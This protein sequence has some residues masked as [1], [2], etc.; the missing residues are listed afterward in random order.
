M[1]ASLIAVRAIHFAAQI[2]LAGIFAFGALVAA[3][4]YARVSHPVPLGL[5]R[6]LM[7]GAGASVVLALLSAIPWLL[8]VTQS[9][10]AKPLSV[11]IAQG[12]ILTVLTGTQF[13]HAWALRFGV[14][15]LLIPFVVVLGKSRARDGFAA[16]LGGILLAATAWQGHAGAEQNLDGLVHVGADAIHLVA[17][18]LWL[19]SL[20]PLALLLAAARREAS[21]DGAAVSQAATIAFSEL[22]LRA[23]A[24]LL[25]TGIINAWFLVGSVPGLVGTLYG[26]LLILKLALFAAMVVLA[27]I[28]RLRLLPRLTLGDYGRK[29]VV[30]RSASRR[31]ERHALIEALLGLAILVIVAALGTQIPAAHEQPWWPFP[32]RFGFDEIGTVPDLRNDAI[33]TAV[34]AL[35]GLVLIAVGWRLRRKLSIVTGCVLF[36][37]LG[38]RPIQ[39]LLIPATPTSYYASAEPYSVRTILAGGRIYT[40][41]CVSCHGEAGQGDGPMAAEL[42]I[43]PADL[44]T[45]LSVHTDGDLYWSISNGMDNGIMPA[46]GA[47]LDATQ[48]WDVIA[49]LRAHAAAVETDALRAEVATNPAPLAPDF[50]FGAADG[51]PGT[52]KAVL[53]GNAVLLALAESAQSPLVL[54]LE[55]SRSVLAANGVVLLAIADDREIRSVYA[56]Y[57]RQDGPEAAP[58][59][60]PVAFLIDRDGYIRARWHPGDT[61]DWRNVDTLTQEITAMGRLKLAPV[62]QNLHVHSPG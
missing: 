5:R 4:A 36:L 39:L 43:A 8:L 62:I 57:D 19:G 34:L 56:L 59:R 7:L 1:D 22:G 50:A 53:A 13:G 15:L 38:W 58:T 35:L 23:V 41:N 17:A 24:A 2:S 40:R 37:G 31:I 52:L 14:A 11:V 32:Y 60:L 54:Q 6:Q 20:L 42:P 25:M 46:F 55:E 27:A 49:A 33:G 10:S 18:G 61:P 3:P 30:G 29:A 51:T 12:I 16:L 45:H 28:N 26:Q 21:R 48:R 44:T 9:M 47:S